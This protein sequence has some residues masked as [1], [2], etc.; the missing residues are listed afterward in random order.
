MGP[1]FIVLLHSSNSQAHLSQ[2]YM[3]GNFW[4]ILMQKWLPN[5]SPNDH[6]KLP[7]SNDIYQNIVEDQSWNY[8]GDILDHYLRFFTIII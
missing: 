5:P 4:N 3:L 2:L 1:E 6:R 7:P 8:S